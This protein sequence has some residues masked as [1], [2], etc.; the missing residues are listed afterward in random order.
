MT[1]AEDRH[2]RLL[3][4]AGEL[5]DDFATRAAEHDLNNSFP[6]ENIQRMKDTG[7]TALVLPEEE[8][9]LGADLVDFCRC[10]ERLAQ[11]CGATALAINMH[12]FGLGS[13][14]ERGDILRPQAQRFLRAV[15]QQRQIMGGGLTEPETGGN[16]GLFVSRAVK[17]GDSYILNGRKAFT[18]LS[19]VIDLFMVLVT[20]QDPDAGLLSGTFLIPKGTPGLQTVENWNAMGMRA[21]ASHDLIITDCRLPLDS[22][23][24]LRPIG[25]ILPE[26]VS[27]FA[28]FSL[29]IASIYTGVAAAAL[30]FAKHFADR[31]QPLPLPRPIKY[32]PGAQFSV[33][34][35][36]TLLAA[37]R[38]YTYETAKAWVAGDQFVGE[39][40]LTRVCMPK[41]FATN[42]A[43]RI[44]DMAMEVVGSVGLFKKHPLERYYRD[45]RAGTN[46]PFS[47]GRMRE[48]IGK[49]AL[50]IKFLEMPRW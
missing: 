20:V 11:G 5:A 8:G 10:Q 22:A 19:P 37:T 21:T 15:G 35:A 2:T 18:S 33:A 47:N 26:D 6:F 23:I 7:Y 31:H 24:R 4:L 49:N 28:W 40:G 29:S 3:T 50:G 13:M 16:W 12:L 44:V 36:E 38:A 46:H 14:V 43:I 1:A 30:N 27:L 34:E 42:N 32:L 39:D 9:G 41:Y 25:E 17:E 48:I 45:V